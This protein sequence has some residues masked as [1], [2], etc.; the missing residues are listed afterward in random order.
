MKIHWFEEKKHVFISNLNTASVFQNANY[1]HTWTSP[2]YDW[3]SSF[4]FLFSFQCLYFF[5]GYVSYLFLGL[6][7][8]NWLQDVDW[9]PNRCIRHQFHRKNA[10]LESDPSTLVRVDL[11]PF[12]DHVTSELKRPSKTIRKLKGCNLHVIL[13]H[14][15]NITPDILAELGI[16]YK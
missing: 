7:F 2:Q 12:I 11:F 14:L 16:I 9:R 8:V 10:A 15:H 4:S 3:D 5:G 1:F 13:K 6:C